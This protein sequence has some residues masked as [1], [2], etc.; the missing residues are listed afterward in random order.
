ME[1]PDDEKDEARLTYG[2]RDMNYTAE[3]Q[4]AE[5]IVLPGLKRIPAPVVS[6][7]NGIS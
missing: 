6:S 2:H 4:A 1:S 7:C 5:A 3:L